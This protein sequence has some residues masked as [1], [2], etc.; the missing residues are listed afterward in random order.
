[1]TKN[2]NASLAKPLTVFFIAGFVAAGTSALFSARYEYTLGNMVFWVL[3]VVLLSGLCAKTWIGWKQSVIALSA[4]IGV[5]LLL[6]YLSF[7]AFE[8][9]TEAYILLNIFIE[10]IGYYPN[11]SDMPFVIGAPI[12]AAAMFA[13]G[14]SAALVARIAG[15]FVRPG[16]TP[17]KG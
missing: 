14:A 9:S 4:Y 3:S 17:L 11:T 12:W 6:A 1:M 2:E 10:R 8:W 13:L 16:S 15:K 7:F 5:C